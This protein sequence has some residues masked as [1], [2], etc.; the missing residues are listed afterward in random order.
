[1]AADALSVAPDRIIM[2]MADTAATEDCGSTSA[3]RSTYIAGLALLQ[4]ANA[5]R[6]AAKGGSRSGKRAVTGEARFPESP[7]PSP[8]PGLLHVMYTFIAQAVK[9]RIDPVTGKVTLLDIFAAT[10]AGRIINPLALAGQI[11]GGIAMSA[12]FALGE[13][14]VF[15]DGHLRNADFSVYLL[16]T[17][18]DIPCIESKTVDSF[19][20]SGPMGIKGAAEVATVAIAPA[21]GAAIA[22]VSGAWFNRLP[23]DMEQIFSA[24]KN[25]LP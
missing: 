23:F 24:V 10:E 22:G 8:A 15:E 3:S 6:K 21:I 5:Y 12:G 19:E 1:M 14:C 9:L 13:N 11:Q 25:S 7:F 16:P 20:G 18:L 17:A 4:A 2:V